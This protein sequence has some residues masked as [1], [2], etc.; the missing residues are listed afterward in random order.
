MTKQQLLEILSSYKKTIIV[1]LLLVLVNIG[2]W[3]YITIFQEPR[4]TRLQNEWTEKRA[5]SVGGKSDVS[6]LYHKGMAD[7]A[8]F[9]ERIPEKREFTRMMMEIFEA[10]ENNGLRVQGTTYKPSTLKEENLVVYGVTLGLEGKYAGVKSFLADLQCMQAMVT[11]DSLS[12]SG[13]KP[14]EESVG[15]RISLSAYLRPEAR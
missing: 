12:L 15:L 4:L 7:L 1:F 11:V 8:V 5:L 2:L 10:A 14:T 9:Q 6:S 3:G 13:G